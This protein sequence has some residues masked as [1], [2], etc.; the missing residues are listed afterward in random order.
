MKTTIS[1]AFPVNFFFR[2]AE[3]AIEIL[4]T[5]I[6]VA[7]PAIF[8]SDLRKSRSESCYCAVLDTFAPSFISEKECHFLNGQ[9]LRAGLPLNPPKSPRRR[10]HRIGVAH[11]ADHQGD[12]VARQL[13]ELR[14]QPT[15]AAETQSGGNKNGETVDHPGGTGKEEEGEQLGEWGES[16]RRMTHGHGIE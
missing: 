5:T 14:A 10:R 16:L 7:F 2:I 12:V 13:L 1:V 9:L 3:I 4:K 6:S 8:F 15:A 11:P